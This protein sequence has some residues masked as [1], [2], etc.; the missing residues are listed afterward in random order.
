M[1]AKGEEQAG[2]RAHDKPRWSGR[3]KGSALGNWI[4][5]QII[6]RFGP[7]PAYA[8]SA[9][10]SFRYAL[11]D[12]Q[13]GRALRAFRSHLGLNT[14]FAHIYR[15]V[16]SFGVNLIDSLAFLTGTSRFLRFSRIG[17][18]RIWELL[19]GGKGLIL[20][21]AHVGNWE[22]AA[23]LL[24]HDRELTVNVVMRDNERESIRRVLK[25]ATEK[26]RVNV[27]AVSDDALDTMLRL[28]A[29]LRRNEVVCFLGDRVM[30]HE[31]SREMVFLGEKAR[32]PTG[33]F[34]IGAITGAPIVTVLTVKKGLRDYVHRAYMSA[35]LEGARGGER[36]AR[37]DE[38]MRQFVSTLEQTVREHPY[39]WFNFYDFWRQ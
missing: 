1:G 15:H 2:G 31:E 14:R 5:V 9:L 3:S 17:E 36:S 13:T 38:A 25:P 8:L 16:F 20:L 18:D 7:L 34:L 37:V 22:V 24:P 10:V 23:N 30:G 27:I 35:S 26:R 4:F 29:A 21:S 19:E 6:R 33:P 28:Q 11:L 12:R 39:Q 32:F